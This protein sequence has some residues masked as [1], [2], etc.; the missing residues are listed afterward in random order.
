MDPSGHQIDRPGEPHPRAGE[1]FSLDAGPLHGSR[2][3]PRR[4]AHHVARIM[5]AF[6]GPMILGEHGVR[7]VGHEDGEAFV[8][9]VDAD[10]GTDRRVERQQRPGA[11]GLPGRS[12]RDVGVGADHAGALELGDDA[13]DR[14]A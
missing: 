3:E 9:D 11:A 1:L 14:R 13:R 12:D 7:G 4:Q 6:E 10:D 2:D 5:I 8:V